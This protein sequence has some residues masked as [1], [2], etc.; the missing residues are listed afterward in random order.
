MCRHSQFLFLIALKILFIT[1]THKVNIQDSFSKE[2]LFKIPFTVV[3][4]DN[5]CHPLAHKNSKNIKLNH[6][7]WE[8]I[9]PRPKILLWT[10][11]Y[12]TYQMIR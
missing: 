7:T 2:K 3:Q 5:C 11:H 12:W 6:K 9:V 8:Y 1:L 10:L 4:R